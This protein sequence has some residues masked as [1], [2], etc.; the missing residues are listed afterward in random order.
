[1]GRAMN[2]KAMHQTRSVRDMY[3]ACADVGEGESADGE[4]EDA[5]V[6]EEVVVED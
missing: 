1:M 3:G 4:C 2:E 6:T 5:L